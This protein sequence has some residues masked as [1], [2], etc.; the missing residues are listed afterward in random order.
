MDK[1]VIIGG[2][3]TAVVI[4]EQIYD[5]QHRFGMNIEMLGF[6]FD[7]ESFGSEINGFQIL[8][9]TYEAKE[10]FKDYNDI[11]FIFSLYRPDIMR[12]R[13]SLRDSYQILKEK[14][15]TFIHPSVLVAKS[16]KIG[17]GCVLCANTV[18]NPNV[19]IGEFN[20]INSSCLI[21]HDT[22]IGNNNFFAGHV[23]VGS[24]VRIEDGSFIG[25][26][27]S[28]RNFLSIGSYTFIG[29][30]SN[31]V[32]NVENNQIVVGNPGRVRESLS[33]KVS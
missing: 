22:I 14:F 23:C 10:K 1:V 4:A 26:N 28:I 17:T 6:A 8:C 15:F 31:L 24:N 19:N 25:L 20:T 33:G 2:K 12:E 30:A 16:A 13:I 9:K 3:G 32:K 11:K 27:S 5:A 18:V 29:M 21:G 7:D